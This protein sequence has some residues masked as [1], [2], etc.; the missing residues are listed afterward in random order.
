MPKYVLFPTP[1]E[2]DEQVPLYTTALIRAN[3]LE[4]CLAHTPEGFFAVSNECTHQRADMHKGR[5]LPDSKIQCPWHG[6]TFSLKN[7]EELSGNGCPALKTYPIT[8]S[9]KGVE[10]EL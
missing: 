1:A 4:I 5:V 8:V 6:Y 10:I 9:D 2:A 7:G 3:T